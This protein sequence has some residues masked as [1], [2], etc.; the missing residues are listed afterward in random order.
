MIGQLPL[1]KSGIGWIEKGGKWLSENP[2][3]ALQITKIMFRF[4]ENYINRI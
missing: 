1:E 4:N 3:I 2:R